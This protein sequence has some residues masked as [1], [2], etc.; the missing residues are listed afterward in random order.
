MLEIKHII[1]I[2]QT[3]LNKIYFWITNSSLICWKYKC[4][5]T[6]YKRNK[7]SEGKEKGN[8][9]VKTTCFLLH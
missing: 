3:H 9:T 6:I 7:Q 2:T 4:L 8:P 1:H 5:D